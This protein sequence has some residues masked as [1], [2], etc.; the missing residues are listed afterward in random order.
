MS[1]SNRAVCAFLLLAALL[2]AYSNHFQNDFHFDDWHTVTSNLYIQNIRNIPRFFEDA[3]TFSVLPTHQN[4]RPV[5]SATLAVDYRLA[6]GLKP[7]WFHIDTFIWYVALLAA[8]Y[9]MYLHLM[10]AA[11]PD[12]RNGYL[13]F[14]AVALFGLHPV[15]AESV[16][17]IVQRGEIQSTLG[18]AAGMAIFICS[19]RSR[20]WGLYLIPVVIGTLAKPPALMFAPILAVYIY[21]FES[22]QSQPEAGPGGRIRYTFRALTP[23]LAVTVGLVLLQI[24]MTP[25]TWQGDASSRYEYWLT[26]PSVVLHYIK[27]FFIPTELTADTDR[28]V[29]TSIYGE[30]SVISLAFLGLIALSIRPALKKPEM[31]PAAFGALWFV[32]ALLPTCIQPLAEVDN[33]HRMFFPFVG[34][35]LAVS[36]M[37]LVPLRRFIDRRSNA[38]TWAMAA[39]SAG[40]LILGACIWGTRQRNEVW[41]TDKSLWKDV[42]E[43]SPSNGRGLMNYGLALMDEGD[44]KG[45]LDYYLDADNYTPKYSTLKTNEG[46]AYGALGDDVK[47]EA[48]F[49]ESLTLLPKDSQ[50]YFFFGQWLKEKKRLPEAREMLQHAVEMS[51][52][53][54]DS[55]DLLMEIYSEQGDAADLNKLATETLQLFPTNTTAANF[56]TH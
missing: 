55:R 5:V 17:Y 49:R 47:A 2:T 32:L 3:R 20:K 31:R 56:L 34:L 45:A 51:P 36:W 18:V 43:K 22:A 41:H 53:D 52:S 4:Y 44:Y 48:K 15:C 13:A 30:T 7:A 21:L 46:I 39:A 26:Q 14:F 27:S 40:I 6:G 16:N 35:T 9:F 25:K 50:N 23:A 1:R 28:D 12:P 11:Q 24:V 33:D 54:A 8:M 38:R 19:P 37:A 10:E 42:T 29:V